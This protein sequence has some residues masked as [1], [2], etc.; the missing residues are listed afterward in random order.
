[1]DHGPEVGP[2]LEVCPFEVEGVGVLQGVLEAGE[3]SG[4]GEEVEG[5]ARE[6]CL[7]DT[8]VSDNTVERRRQANSSSL[9][10]S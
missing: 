10:P 2:L 3:G 4:L 5:Y 7:R 9:R 8:A 1:M 6:R